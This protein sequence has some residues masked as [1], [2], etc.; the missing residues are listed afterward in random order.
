HHHHDE[1]I[2]M[3]RRRLTVA[4]VM[5][6]PLAALAMI[7]PLQVRG[8]EWVALALGTPV[9]FWNGAGFHRVALQAARHFT[10]TMDTLIALGTLC[11][12]AWSV[13]ALVGGLDEDTYFEVAAVITTLILLGRYLEAR[14][15]WRSGE[16]IR[17]LLELGAKEARVVRDGRELAIAIEDVSTGDLMLVGP[18]EKIP[19]DG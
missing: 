6:A 1:P 12:Y 11:A 7:P 8:W 10:A 19:T 16:A 4:V 14:A 15:K 5:T 2:A 3:L 17:T 18:G 13:A 9:V